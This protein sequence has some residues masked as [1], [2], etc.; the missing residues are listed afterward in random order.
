[1]KYLYTSGDR[2][3]EGYTVK[4]GLGRGGFGEV[5]RAVSDG[6]KEVA[7]KLVQRNLEVELRGVG[8][9]LN[10][11]H[12]NLVAL[13]DI[14]Q[15]TGGDFWVVMEYVGGETLDKVIAGHPQG[16]P[17]DEALAWV[18]GICDGLAYLHA[19]GLVHRD[20]KPGNIF[21]EDGVVK[22]GDYGLSK[23]I[24]ASRRSGQTASV[25]TVH[26]MPPEIGQGRYGKEVDLYALGVILHEMLAGRVPFDGETP[27]EILMKHLTALPD[28]SVLPPAFRPVVA[29]LLNKDPSQRYSSVQAVLAD[30]E[31]YLASPPPTG[32]WSGAPAYPA[33]VPVAVPASRPTA[34]PAWS[35]PVPT[36]S[37]ASRGV[38][39]TLY[40]LIAV[41]VAVGGG[42]LIGVNDY[43]PRQD[44]S[45]AAAASGIG[46]GFLLFAGLMTAYLLFR[47]L[48]WLVRAALAPP[49]PA[50]G[51]SARYSDAA[52]AGTGSAP[53]HP[54]PAPAREG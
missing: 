37:L 10:L 34:T 42:I 4:H 26:Y 54:W 25:G 21:R 22:I 33:S 13:H 36:A 11:K 20:L 40:L 16:L 19:H 53:S 50:G 32:P 41:A 47:G 48:V 38:P 49:P 6:G 46:S 30:L 17:P 24:S 45:G 44:N 9:C 52:A 8:Q 1:M 29:R 28:V 15:T 35:G 7:L 31:G 2:P 23:F 39:F 27:G 43:V 51:D 12:P 18:R 5:Y 3:L 14:K